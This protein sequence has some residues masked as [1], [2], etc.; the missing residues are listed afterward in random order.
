MYNLEWI[1]PLDY[2][3]QSY[4]TIHN[5]KITFTFYVEYISTTLSNSQILPL[6]Y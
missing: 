1:F 5:D 2:L 4:L 6:I 3:F